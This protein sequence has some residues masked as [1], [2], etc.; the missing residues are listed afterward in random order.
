MKARSA[1]ISR[2]RSNGAGASFQVAHSFGRKLPSKETVVPRARAALA[3]IPDP[4]ASHLPDIV[5]IDGGKGQVGVAREVF[6][7]LGLDLGR[8]VGVEKGEG[9][10][11]GL[12]ELVFADGREVSV[13]RLAVGMSDGLSKLATHALLRPILGTPALKLVCH[14]GEVEELMA[15]L[16]LHRLDLVLAGQRDAGQGGGHRSDEAARPD[17]RGRG[18]H[19]GMEMPVVFERGNVGAQMLVCGLEQALVVTRG[20]EIAAALHIHATVVVVGRHH[21][22]Q[23]DGLALGIR[24]FDADHV[25]TGHDRDAR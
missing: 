13:A 23:E 7:A 20:M 11:V 24:Q 17:Q 12:E 22:A 19:I 2:L 14:E 16:A 5:L 25:A 18:L 15:E 6:E 1:S 8:L 9:R 10:K 21:L 4:F 3:R